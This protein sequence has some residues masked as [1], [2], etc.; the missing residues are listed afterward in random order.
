MN[1]FDALFVALA[2]LSALAYL[3]RAFWPKGD[4]NGGCACP[5]VHCKI[6]KVKLGP[7]S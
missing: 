3:V 6:A 4:R 5:S 7:P 2:V 1:W